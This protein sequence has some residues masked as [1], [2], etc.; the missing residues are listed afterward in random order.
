MPN[1]LVIRKSCITG[2]VVWLYRGSSKTAARQAYYRA[3]KRVLSGVNDRAAK[4]E[5]YIFNMIN[6]CI[7]DLDVTQPLN[8]EQKSAIRQLK[9]LAKEQMADDEEFREHVIEEEKRRR[10]A[11]IIRQ[12]MR[13]REAKK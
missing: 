12:K 9:R 7:A 8:A 10:E 2:H 11:K 6:E 3:R 13:E 1:L 5:K 4:Q